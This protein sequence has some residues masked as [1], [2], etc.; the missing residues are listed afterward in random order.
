MIEQLPLYVSLIFIVTALLTVWLFLKSLGPGQAASLPARLL[1][2]L[3]P[4]WFILQGVLGIGDFY[5]Y[6]DTFPPRVF[7]FG[8]FPVLL[9]IA[10]Y[11]AFFRKKLVE[12]LSTKV[13]TIL[14]VVRIPVEFVLLWLFQ[15]GQVPRQMTFEGWN[16]DILSGLTAPIIYFLAFRNGKINRPLLIV[17]NLA[18]LG[19][20]ANVVTIAFLSFKS[21]M[22]QIAFAQP[23][24]AITY[25]PFIWLPTIVVPAVLFAHLAALWNLL[26]R[27]EK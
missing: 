8:V 6:T 12:G 21:P 24:I 1:L 17:W 11:F 2:F 7:L 19:L 25:F 13:L 18:A 10:V 3:I 15:S 16:L 14:H 20:L 5:H 9:L 22:Q 4:F 26:K 27:R 23:N